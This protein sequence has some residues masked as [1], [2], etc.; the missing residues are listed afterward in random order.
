[1]NCISEVE[2]Y[3]TDGLLLME[4]KECKDSLVASRI[5]MKTDFKMH[6]KQVF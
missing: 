2:K 4:L 6:I 3:A 1:M 5:Y